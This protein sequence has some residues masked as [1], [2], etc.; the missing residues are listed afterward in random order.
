MPTY[1]VKGSRRSGRPREWEP[2]ILDDLGETV[3]ML[4]C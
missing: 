1:G 4:F 2:R 3:F